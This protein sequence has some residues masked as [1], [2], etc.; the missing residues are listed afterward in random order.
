MLLYLS[1]AGIPR[2]VL[3]LCQDR[4]SHAAEEG[5]QCALH[6]PS[7][8]Q[9]RDHL[10]GTAALLHQMV[11][12]ALVSQDRQQTLLDIVAGRICEQCCLVDHVPNRPNSNDA[13]LAA[14]QKKS[15]VL[16]V[17]FL[18]FMIF[19]LPYHASCVSLILT[20]SLS[21]FMNLSAVLLDYTSSEDSSLRFAMQNINLPFVPG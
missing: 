15:L 19:F 20:E 21:I 14:Y 12:Q 2:M 1:L 4:L 18:T 9:H 6:A 8:S 7:S 16:P 3:Q 5:A 11:G 13:C 10:G 17:G